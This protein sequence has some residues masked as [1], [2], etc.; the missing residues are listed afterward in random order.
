MTQWWLPTDSYLNIVYSY[1]NG[2]GDINEEF[3]I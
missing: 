2:N 3:P 1:I